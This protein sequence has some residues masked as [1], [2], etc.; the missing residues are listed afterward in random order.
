MSSLNPNEKLEPR[1][2]KVSVA[3]AI[4]HGLGGPKAMAKAEADGQTVNIPSRRLDSME[5]RRVVGLVYY[6]FYIVGLRRSAWQ[7]RRAVFNHDFKDRR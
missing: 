4:N 5:R 3:L 1:K 6:W 2:S 7:I